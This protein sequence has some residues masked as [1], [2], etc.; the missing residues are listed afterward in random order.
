MKHRTSSTHIQSLKYSTSYSYL[1]TRM[2][3]LISILHNSVYVCTN[4]KKSMIRIP[5][6]KYL[7]QGCA[8]ALLAALAFLLVFF[9]NATKI[10]T[11]N[12]DEWFRSLSINLKLWIWISRLMNQTYFKLCEFDVNVVRVPIP[13]FTYKSML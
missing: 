10:K 9:V 8:F 11:V 3:L 2:I 7:L 12:V 1:T 6:L 4:H 13:T 5:T